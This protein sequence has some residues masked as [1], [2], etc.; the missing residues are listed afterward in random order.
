MIKCE[1]ANKIFLI[2][3]CF[4]EKTM[5]REVEENAS[6]KPASVADQSEPDSLIGGNDKSDEK[7]RKLSETEETEKN[8]N[9][10]KTIDEISNMLSVNSIAATSGTSRQKYY[11]ASPLIV[12]DRET[13]QEERRRRALEDQKKVFT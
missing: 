11:K 8:D 7:D 4:S 6:K 2:A 9:L 3:R 12:K 10:S 13:T 5:P 1:S